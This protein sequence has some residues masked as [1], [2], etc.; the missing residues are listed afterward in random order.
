MNQGQGSIVCLLGASGTGKTQLAKEVTQDLSRKGSLVIWG[1][2]NPM[3]SP[4]GIIR[5][6]FESYFSFIQ[7]LPETIRNKHEQWVRHSAGKYGPLL[8]SFTPGFS[9]ILEDQVEIGDIERINPF[10]YEILANFFSELSRMAGSLVLILDDLQSLDHSSSEVILLLAKASQNC[11]LLL[12]VTSE[13]NL[14]LP[15]LGSAQVLMLEMHPLSAQEVTLFLRERLGNRKIDPEI[16]QLL[17]QKSSGNPLILK[18]YLDALFRKNFIYPTWEKWNLQVPHSQNSLLPDT[19]DDLLLERFQSF[20]ESTQLILKFAALIGPVSSVRMLTQ[21]TGI[22]EIDVIHQL[23]EVTGTSSSEVISFGKIALNHQCVRTF[24]GA[25]IP[26]DQLPEYHVKIAES[27]NT[28]LISSLDCRFKATHHLMKINQND[29]KTHSR[30]LWESLFLS[31]QESA[32]MFAFDEAYGQLFQAAEIAMDHQWPPIASF[33]ILFGNVCYQLERLTE[34]HQHFSIALKLTESKLERFSIYGKLS[35]IHLNVWEL[36]QS[37]NFL[38]KAYLESPHFVP[39]IPFADLLF[40]DLKQINS[41]LFPVLK[42]RQKIAFFQN[43]SSSW[44]ESTS[45]LL[46][47][48]EESKKNE[49]IQERAQKKVL[50]FLL[51]LSQGQVLSAQKLASEILNQDAVWL[52]RIEVMEVFHALLMTLLLQGKAKDALKLAQ[53][54]SFKLYQRAEELESEVSMVFPVWLKN[55]MICSRAF[56]GNDHE[57]ESDF[58]EIERFNHELA[59]DFQAFKF[60]KGLS[61]LALLWTQYEKN[62]WGQ[63]FEETLS[64]FD[65]LEIS[66]ENASPLLYPIYVVQGYGRLHHYFQVEPEVKTQSLESLKKAIL[67][68]KKLP[69]HSLLNSHLKNFQSIMQW[70]EGDFDSAWLSACEAEKNAFESESLWAL[71]EV[72]IQKAR[73]FERQGKQ[74]ATLR[75]LQLP[76]KLTQE[77][78]WVSKTIRIQKE[79]K[80]MI[81]PPPPVHLEGKSHRLD[82]E[83]SAMGQLSPDGMLGG[84]TQSY[85]DA[86]V[87]LNR[88]RARIAKDLEVTGIVHALLLPKETFVNT[89]FFQMASYYQAASQSGGDWWWVEK[90][91]NEGLS[92][93]L[94]DVTGHGAGS[95]MVTAAVASSYRTLISLNEVGQEIDYMWLF[96]KLNSNLCAICEGSYGMTLSAFRFTSDGQ[97]KVWC[98]GTP[99]VM[100]LRHATGVVNIKYIPSTSLGSPDITVAQESFQLEKG[101]RIF[102]F[103]DGV[104]EF[105]TSSRPAFGLKG[106]KKLLAMTQGQNVEQAR[107]TLSMHL[108]A[109]RNSPTLG[110]DLT[111]VLIDYL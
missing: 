37:L 100:I 13:S 12:I 23:A 6:L 82:S 20:S 86:L 61:C 66:P 84:A 70:I 77:Q 16:S 89:S 98:A 56:L 35:D 92:V 31:A 64:D 26:E 33:E 75:C 74:Q 102:A 27:L 46:N 52:D 54:P 110:D 111:F 90:N 69:S 76:F 19:L 91:L 108:N 73:I 93:I 103:T 17:F 101:D 7:T 80:I 99:P 39:P 51:L 24:L 106:L 97:L 85:L 30:S 96:D 55:W 87:K 94:A 21:M 71:A 65:K 107:Q 10:F 11:P 81:P 72:T 88:E 28:P 14:M 59:A 22:S 49:N 79:F 68:L 5:S 109:E 34:A 58:Q 41:A 1:Y 2:G 25:Q 83:I 60:F 104:Y 78:G 63:N 42:R 29:L 36:Q 105:Q 67:D 18:F 45:R 8:K 43:Y 38:E 32:Q 3:A 48:L 40:K 50:H 15:N 47:L 57:N 44:S 95:A 53:N 4:F 62:E 9:Q